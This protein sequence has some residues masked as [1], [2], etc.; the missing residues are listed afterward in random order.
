VRAWARTLPRGGTVID[1][2]CGSGLP[3]TKVLLS[4]GLKVF[5]VDGS[6]SLVKAFR[7]NLPDVPVACESIEESSFFDRTF[8]GVCSWG[9]MFLLPSETQRRLI[10]SMA[11]ILVPGGRLLF[12]SVADA[13]VW[14]DAMTGLESRSLGAEEYRRLLS[15]VGFQ[16]QREFEDAGHN[17]YFDAVKNAR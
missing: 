15:A 2:G 12:T 17:H 4:E 14:T 13:L 5:G 3:I 7:E 9:L 1:I 8:D 10:Q 6:P 16:V 11:D